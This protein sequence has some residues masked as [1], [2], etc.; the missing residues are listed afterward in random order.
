MLRVVAGPGVAIP[1][2]DGF[3][4]SKGLAP[5]GLIGV[6]GPRVNR[7]IQQ[8]RMAIEGL[9]G[10]RGVLHDCQRQELGDDPAISASVLGMPSDAATELGSNSMTISGVAA[11]ATVSAVLRG[12]WVGSAA[13]YG[14]EVATRASKLL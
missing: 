6:A 5:L 11:A 7:A 4:T 10:L 3:G 13:L 2:S 12:S 9:D 8:I 14:S 1:H